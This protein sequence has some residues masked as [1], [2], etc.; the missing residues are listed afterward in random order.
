MQQYRGY[1]RGQGATPV[2]GSVE[3]VSPQC[4]GQV[5][6]LRNCVPTILA[7]VEDWEG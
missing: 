4:A 2:Q 7:S 5:E 1:A 3:V 6:L